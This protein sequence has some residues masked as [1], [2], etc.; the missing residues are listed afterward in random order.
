MLIT[1]IDIYIYKYAHHYRLRGVED[2]PRRI[3]DTDYFF[4]PY[5]RHSYSRRAEACLVKITTD[6]GLAGWGEA[7]APLLPEM[8]GMVVQKLF[9][10]F[11]IGMNPLAREC[12]YD[13]LYHIN[14]V[15]GH[16][17]GFTVD[18]IAAIDVALWDI[19]GRHYGASIAELAGGPFT[20]RLSAYVSGL[21]QPT[22]EA[23]CDAARQYAKE[24]H[25]GVKLFLGR[26]LKEDIPIIRAIRE[27]TGPAFSLFCDCL[28]RY[29]LDEAIRLGRILDQEGY[30]WIEA[31]LAPEDVAGHRA[32]AQ[33]LDTPVAVGEPLRTAYEFLPWLE[34]EALEIAQPDVMR[35]GVTAAR[36]IAALAEARRIPVAPHAGMGTGVGM[37]ATWQFAA[38]IPNFLIQEFQ[39][40]LMEQANEI[41]TPPLETDQGTLVVSD[42][43]GLGVEVNEKIVAERSVAHWQVG[44]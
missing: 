6:E 34:R 21:R 25:A 29:R 13:Q 36:K 1:R 43:P 28:W 39:L 24:G 22:L 23:Q 11:L 12:I 16:G 30:G 15:R 7:Q 5:G 19:A 8:A 41:L 3:A 32:L 4:D 42:R 26:G 35:A 31:P 18:A 17:S 14:N 9:G 10:P 44:G 2:T 40:E 33:A 27:A 37:A 38:S 20:D